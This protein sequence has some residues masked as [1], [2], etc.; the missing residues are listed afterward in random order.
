MKQFMMLSCLLLI[1]TFAYGQKRANLDPSYSTRNYKHANQVV[2]ARQ[3]DLSRPVILRQTVVVSNSEYKHRYNHS[4]LVV[5]SVLRTSK[6]RR[7]G[8]THKHPLGL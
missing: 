6:V 5:K 1:V 8:S 4:G 3:H 2:Y 7:A